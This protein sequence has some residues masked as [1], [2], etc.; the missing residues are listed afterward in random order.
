MVTIG[1]ATLFALAEKKNPAAAE[2]GQP[3][4]E[5]REAKAQQVFLPEWVV[6]IDG[7]AEANGTLM[8]VFEPKN[9]EKKLLR[10][11]VVAKEKAKQIASDLANQFTFSIGAAY[12]VKVNGNKIV[13]TQKD[14][15]A[16]GFAIEIKEQALTGVS[17]RLTKG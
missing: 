5:P 11:N 4:T 3:T 16:P 10:V 1:L 13:V 15:K 2:P 17:V 14:K 12:K 7:R 9:G 6:V 8:L